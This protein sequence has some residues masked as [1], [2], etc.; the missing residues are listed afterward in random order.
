MKSIMRTKSDFFFFF[1]FFFQKNSKRKL[2]SAETELSLKL[3]EMQKYSMLM[4]TSCGWF[5][6][7]F[8]ELKP[9]RYLNMRQKHRACKRCF[10]NKHRRKFSADAVRCKKS[11][12]MI[13]LT[14]EIY[15]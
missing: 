9:Y 14:E 3:L 12:S 8:P 15:I 10:R 2:S 1:F 13:I 7:I 11:N 4:F 5:F 6:Q